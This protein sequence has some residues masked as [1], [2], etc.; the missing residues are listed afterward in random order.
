[1]D[2]IVASKTEEAP[3]HLLVNAITDCAIY[4][5]GKDG[6]ISSWNSGAERLNGYK[7]RE[8]VGKHFSIFY[9]DEDRRDGLPNRA[10]ETAARDGRY[11]GEG[12]RLRK[13]GS[14][15]WAHVVIN[16]IY[17]QE[18]SSGVHGYAKITRD[19]TEQMVARRA[20]WRSENQFSLL[21]RNVTDYA[22]YL[23][24]LDGNVSSWNSGAERIKG[25][26]AHEIVGRHFS[27]FYTQEDQA[28]GEPMQALHTAAREGRFATEGWRVR[29]DG[30]VFWASVVIDVIL[31]GCE[32]VGFAKIT[33][34][35]SD[36]KKAQLD[37]ERARDGLFRSQKMAAVGHLTSGAAHDFNR[38]L[39]SRGHR[40]PFSP[41]SIRIRVP[42]WD[43]RQFMTSPSGRAVVSFCGANRGRAPLRSFGCQ[44]RPARRCCQRERASG[45]TARGSG[46]SSKRSSSSRSTMT[47]CRSCRRRQC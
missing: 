20:L 5:L 8:V 27:R 9:A 19:L 15:F 29:K 45:Q 30:G 36:T 17:D 46:R 42:G 39:A 4:M 21:V 47:G 13:D 3:L 26:A 10:L 35:L 6:R 25:Y 1:M 12:W 24:D 28:K 37:L 16:P 18:R 2:Q 11:E 7:E 44:N 43:C 38:V 23:L 40:R 32:I 31:D 41:P 33:R 22:I 34:D 14:R